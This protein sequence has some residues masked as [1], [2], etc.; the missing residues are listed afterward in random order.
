[1]KRFSGTGGGPRFRLGPSGKYKIMSFRGTKNIILSSL[2]IVGLYYFL[3]K[4]LVAGGKKTSQNVTVNVK[5]KGVTDT[6]AGA[7][8]WQ[9]PARA[10]PSQVVRKPI[11][12]LTPK[13]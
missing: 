3:V 1:M 12:L 11:A 4:P 5:N 8:K 2:I 7:S 6:N 9:Q 13:S 10:F